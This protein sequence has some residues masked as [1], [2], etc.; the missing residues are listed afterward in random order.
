M[1]KHEVVGA[2]EVC[3]YNVYKLFQILTT[4]IWKESDFASFVGGLL[5]A[6]HLY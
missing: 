5:V 4:C 1:N 6:A 2:F 3:I